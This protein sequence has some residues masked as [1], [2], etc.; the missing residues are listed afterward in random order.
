MKLILGLGNPGKQYQDTRHNAGFLV[1][2]HLANQLACSWKNDKKL[3]AKTAKCKYQ[4]N[5]ILLVM[6]QTFMN[7]SGKA[8]AAAMSYYKIKSSDILVIHDDLDLPLGGFAI[9]EGGGTAGHN[10]IASLYEHIG[11]KRITRLRI[12]IGRPENKFQDTADWVLSPLDAKSAKIFNTK[13][14]KLTDCLL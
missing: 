3:F 4:N 9:L 2:D 1:L 12:G 8:L 10:G 13:L 11:R 5:D 6:P 7:L 14:N